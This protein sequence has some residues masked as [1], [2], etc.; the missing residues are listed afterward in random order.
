MLAFHSGSRVDFSPGAVVDSTYR[1]EGSELILPPATKH[2][3]EE[4][5]KIDFIGQNQ[6]RMGQVAF[7]RL[8]ASPDPQNLI[9]GEWVAK[10]EMDGHEMEVHYIF[11]TAGKLLF[12]LPFKTAPGRYVINGSL[13]KL[14]LPQRR[15]VEGPFKIE[16]DTLTIPSPSGSGSRFRRY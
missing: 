3:P 11:Y 4:R 10:R 5:Q 7:T 2:G 13:M 16:G 14:E 12:L 1:I 9:L 15:P 8:G 6:L